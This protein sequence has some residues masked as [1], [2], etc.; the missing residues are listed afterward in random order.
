MGFMKLV[1]FDCNRDY[2]AEPFQYQCQCGGLF[3]VVHNFKDADSE[4]LR[5]NFEERLSERMT[6]FASGVW[7]YKELIYPELPEAFIMT[8]YEGNTGLYASESLQAYTGVRQLWLKA[9]SENPSGS[10]K[11]NGMTV[12]VSH[13][14]FLGKDKLACSSTGNTSSSLAM[15]AALAGCKAY[16]YG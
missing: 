10:F 8:K 11:D 9:Q 1:C 2:S 4:F 14:R 3:E 7:R 15:Y 5:R 16:V 6:V 13:A 12:A